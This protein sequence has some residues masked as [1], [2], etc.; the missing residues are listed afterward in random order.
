C[1]SVSE[2]LCCGLL[3]GTSRIARLL[4]DFLVAGMAVE[5]PRRRELAEFV[6][7]HVFGHEH[8][9]V[10]ETVVDAEGQADE[11]RQDGR[12]PRPD[13]DDVL[14]GRAARGL[15]LLQHIAVDKRAF[16]N[17]TR[18]CLTLASSW[19][20]AS[21]R[22]PCR[23]ACSCGSCTPWSGGPMASPDDGRPWCG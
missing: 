15:C 21:A 9:N 18:H 16:P 8:R 12:T 7:H 13:L 1:W 5:C 6:T 19:R 10:L 11:L 17:R 14:A 3:T 20:A 23:S 2:R 22:C 4:G